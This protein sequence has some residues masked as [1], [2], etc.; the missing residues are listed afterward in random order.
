MD[1]QAID[2]LKRSITAL[3]NQALDIPTF[4][5]R[6]REEIERV[7]PHDGCC[8]MT[9]DPATLLPTSHIPYRSIPP[10]QV[11]RLAQN[12]YAEDDVN[13][14][15]AL[16]RASPNVGVHS[17]ATGGHREESIRYRELLKPNGF[18]NELRGVFNH[19]GSCWGGAALYRGE[20][21][22]DFSLEEALALASISELMADG[23]R[24]A[25][26]TQAVAIVDPI[27]APGLVLVDGS[28]KLE[29]M[30]PAAKIWIDEL[31]VSAEGSTELPSPVYALV[32]R[33]RHAA[34]SPD[35]GPAQVR[36]RTRN[37]QWVV[38]HG[39]LVEGTAEG[40]I[41]VIF[42]QA[43]APQLAPLIAAAYGL[44]SRERD[45][46]G[47]VIQGSSTKEIAERLSLSPHTVQDHLKSTFNKVGVHSRRELVTQVFSEQYAPRM[48][49]AM[50]V[51]AD[52][53]FVPE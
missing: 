39:S 5:G 10:E 1:V 28:G 27:D 4:F 52:G 2:R 15:A 8:A 36:A 25:A 11:P 31:V 3:C 13:K 34:D 40:R 41:A 43:R 20:D 48:G 45:I 18:E 24:R 44:T 51:G 6:A 21:V 19:D 53:W 35:A 47:L 49:A 42:E 23:I 16:W 30:N 33:T 7:L 50:P 29:A 37:G 17:V 26:L 46:A 12:E 38:M 9:F 32:Q 22:P 14:F